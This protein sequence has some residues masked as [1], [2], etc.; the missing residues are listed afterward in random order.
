[1]DKN[2]GYVLAVRMKPEGEG[3]FQSSSDSQ[4]PDPLH[5]FSLDDI[6]IRQRS[7]HL[8]CTVLLM[9]HAS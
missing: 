8:S 1:M 7:Q 6:T 2:V 3:V 4:R 9:L 5:F